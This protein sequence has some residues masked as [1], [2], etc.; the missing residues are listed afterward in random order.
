VSKHLKIWAE[1]GAGSL[2]PAVRSLLDP[3]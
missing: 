2:G 3:L 1:Q